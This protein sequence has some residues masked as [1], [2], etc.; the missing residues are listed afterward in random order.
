[1]KRTEEKMET[2]AGCQRTKPELAAPRGAR[3][4]HRC[5]ELPPQEIYDGARGAH[6]SC[7]Q[8]PESDALRFVSPQ[9]CR[10]CMVRDTRRVRI[11]HKRSATH[12]QHRHQRSHT[13]HWGSASRHGHL[14]RHGHFRMTAYDKKPTAYLRDDE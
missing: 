7:P 6:S 12:A 14:R 4:H 13:R 9:S 8:A 2:G 11:T 3:I 10:A 5:L 1:M